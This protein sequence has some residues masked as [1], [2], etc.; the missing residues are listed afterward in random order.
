[1]KI[2]SA[3]RYY[4]NTIEMHMDSIKQAFEGKPFLFNI[5]IKLYHLAIMSSDTAKMKKLNKKMD[6]YI[7]YCKDPLVLLKYKILS[8]YHHFYYGDAEF[9]LK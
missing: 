5:D 6:S 8:A 3:Q 9:G 1:M 2:V 4:E 7:D